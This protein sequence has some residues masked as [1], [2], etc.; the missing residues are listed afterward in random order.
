MDRRAVTRRASRLARYSRCGNYLRRAPYTSRLC[1]E[2]H[3]PRH[4]GMTAVPTRPRTAVAPCARLPRSPA[5]QPDFARSVS[6][7]APSSAWSQSRPALNS[8]FCPIY[9]GGLTESRRRRPGIGPGWARRTDKATG[10]RPRHSSELP[11]RHVAGVSSLR[12][13][14]TFAQAGA[15]SPAVGP[16]CQESRPPHS[17]SLFMPNAS[18]QQS[19]P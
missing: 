7:R 9:A 15:H 2:R 8:I 12:S 16:A 11:D 5:R 19:C 14:L 3:R 17:R 13:F 1:L 10:V 18:R 6:A 4:Y